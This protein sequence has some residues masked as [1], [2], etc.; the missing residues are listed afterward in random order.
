MS[1]IMAGGSYCP[2]SPDD[3]PHRIE[4]R[5]KVTQCR[6]VVIQSSAAYYCRDFGNTVSVESVIMNQ[7][8]NNFEILMCLSDIGLTK[9]S[10]AYVVF[11]SGS[12]GNPK[13][14]S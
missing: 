14:V 6:L 1:I 13:G 12:T 11:T 3:P 9:E 8:K 5:I 4:Q 10:I 2:L 7:A